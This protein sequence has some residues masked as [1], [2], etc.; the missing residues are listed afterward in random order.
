MNKI[1]IHEF[2]PVIYPRRLWIVVTDDIKILRENFEF[3]E[4]CENYFERSAAFVFNVSQ[5][6]TRMIGVCICFVRRKHFT[7]KNISHESV[8]AA[9]SIFDGLG[10]SMGFNDGKDEHYA[11]LVG[12]IAECCERVK[13]NKK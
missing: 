1:Q 9:S 2:D 3:E 11:Y 13:L 8:H 6:E 12:W 4:D 7:I 5:K 10:M